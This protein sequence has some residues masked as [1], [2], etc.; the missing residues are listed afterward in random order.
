MTNKLK[1][2]TFSLPE[3]LIR[4]LKKV[5]EV[6]HAKSVNFAVREAIALYTSKIEKENLRKEM[7]SA[8]RDPLFLKDVQRSMDSFKTSDKETGKLITDW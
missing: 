6:G 5:V 7:E 3:N 1:N 4:D 8:S 2:V